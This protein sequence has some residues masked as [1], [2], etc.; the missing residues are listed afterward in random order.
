LKVSDEL[1]ETEEPQDF[2]LQ[3]LRELDHRTA[4]AHG[5]APA[6]GL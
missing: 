3:A 6:G 5:R 4:L 2:Y 1:K